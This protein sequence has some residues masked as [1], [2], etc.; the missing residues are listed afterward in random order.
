MLTIIDRDL[1]LYPVAAHLVLIGLLYVWLSAI[2]KWQ[3]DG[4]DVAAQEARISATLSNQFEAPVLFY[5]VVAMIWA[6]D[7]VNAA[8]VALGWVFVAGRLWHIAV[9]TLTTH[10]IY[11][12]LVFLINFIAIV[13]MWGL[14]L[15]QRLVLA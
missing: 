5:A 15:V 8:Y 14:F 11:R 2:R 1:I 7:M 13:A 4:R 9:A 10:I 3:R 6:A 12:G